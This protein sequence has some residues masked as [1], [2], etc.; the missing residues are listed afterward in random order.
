MDNIKLRIYKIDTFKLYSHIYTINRLDVVHS[1][2]IFHDT[3]C[4]MED[5]EPH[6]KLNNALITKLKEMYKDEFRFYTNA[7]TKKIYL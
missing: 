6:S 1:F 5:D 7:I 3:L 4:T 2:Q